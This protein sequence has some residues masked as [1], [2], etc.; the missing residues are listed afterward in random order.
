M[1]YL[2]EDDDVEMEASSDSESD[3]IGGTTSRDSEGGEARDAYHPRLTRMTS[4]LRFLPSFPGPE[5]DSTSSKSFSAS[6]SR[7]RSR[8]AARRQHS[9]DSAGR[10][11]IPSNKTS[12]SEEAGK[13]NREASFGGIRASG[14]KYFGAGYFDETRKSFDT[15]DVAGGGSDSDQS[16]ESVDADEN[17]AVESSV[18]T[19]KEDTSSPARPQTITRNLT[20]PAG[21]METAAATT[22]AL[23]LSATESEEKAPSHAQSTLS[24]RLS[25]GKLT[26]RHSRVKVGAKEVRV[27]GRVSEVFGNGGQCAPAYAKCRSV[28]Y[29]VWES[30][31]IID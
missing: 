28:S 22:A 2:E 17:T 15:A 4:R 3:A 19:V 14:S 10:A 13:L 6:S 8:Y 16:K 29:K 30:C 11:P 25:F 26:P 20:A 7:L 24:K 9:T 12:T 31:L 23:T 21:S 27:T 5:R 18:P 1:G